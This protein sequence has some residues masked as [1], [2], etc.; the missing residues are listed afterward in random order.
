MQAILP[1]LRKMED[2]VKAGELKSY[3]II[4]LHADVIFNSLDGKDGVQN[5]TLS[6]KVKKRNFNFCSIQN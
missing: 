4:K 2:I 5:G 3:D 6:F 1:K